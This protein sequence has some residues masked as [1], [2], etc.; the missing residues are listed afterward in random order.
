MDTYN[1]AIELIK[2]SKYTIVFTGAGISKESG[3]PAFRDEGGL[4]NKYDPKILELSYYINNT[5]E[6]WKVVK[7]IFYDFFI[8]A[9]PNPAHKVL[10]EWEKQG[11]VKSIIT[12]NIDS[13]HQKAGSNNVIEFHGT[14]SSFVCLECNA[15]FKTEA[16]EFSDNVPLCN[17]CNFKLK[18]NFI[19]FGEA[20]P[21]KASQQSLAET[22]NAEL[23]IIIGTTGE[24]YPAAYIPYEAKQNG[25]KILEINPEKSNFSDSITD[26]MI[27]EKAGI[28]LTKLNELLKSI[29]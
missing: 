25:A 15:T 18:P 8:Q 19:F 5:E 11:I 1:Q 20:I 23:V 9:K 14:N 2:N 7:N 4:W 12:Q 16:L 21:V 6:S 28:A 27:Q 22:Q 17:I 26:V 3:I 10:A 13:L 24:V 29:Q